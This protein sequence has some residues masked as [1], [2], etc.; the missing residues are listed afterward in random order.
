MGNIGDGRG[1]GSCVTASVW[2]RRG[3]CAMSVCLNEFCLAV[4]PCGRFLFKISLL[5]RQV[6]T[7]QDAAD[8]RRVSPQTGHEVMSTSSLSWILG[9][10][11]VCG[12]RVVFFCYYS[13]K[14]ISIL[15]PA[16]AKCRMCRWFVDCTRGSCSESAVHPHR[17][18]VG[19]NTG[20]RNKF[21]CSQHFIGKSSTPCEK[22]SG[23]PSRRWQ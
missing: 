6:S 17:D 2:L 10:M 4:V 19:R 9:T 7:C 12:Q 1:R 11:Y 20:K 23:T 18:T 22:M 15:A 8:T 13:L 16:M 3:N 14:V 5:R 21:A